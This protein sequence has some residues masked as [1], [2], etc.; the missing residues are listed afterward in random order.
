MLTKP[1]TIG[2]GRDK[3]YPHYVLALLCMANLLSVADRTVVALLLEPIKRDLGANDTQMSALTGAAFVILYTVIGIPVARW[4]DRGNRRSILAIGIAAWSLA[5]VACGVA[6]NFVQ[7]LFARAGVGMG[8]STATPTSMSLIADYYSRHVRPQAIAVF[9]LAQPLSTILLTP[10]IGIVADAH[11]WRAAL[12]LLGVPGVLLALLIRFTVRE[13]ERG[14]KDEPGAR[15]K[16]QATWSAA[17]KA[18]FASRPFMLILIGTAIT[19]LGNGTLGAWGYAMMMRA[20]GVSATEVASIAAPIGAISGFV[21]TLLGGYLTPWVAR[22]LGDQRWLVLLPAIAAVLT[23]PGALLYVFAPSWPWM[24]VGLVIGS[25]TNAFRMSPYLALSLDIV[26]S[27]YRG[28]ASAVILIATN[29]IG[30][31]MGPLI[32]GMI[33]DALTPSLGPVEGLRVAF[34]FAPATVALG[35]IPFFM[36]VRCF[37]REGVKPMR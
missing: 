35:V 19:G 30:N 6:N 17:L 37:N 9:N 1:E 12:M 31:A 36:A 25:G 32:V 27:V 16:H 3:I 18:M 14:R 4:A 11:G 8:E 22:K 7:M 28:M 29:V 13:P 23:I 34:M 33:S 24:I 26:P 15:T 10:V 21:C 2:L 5:T 20:F